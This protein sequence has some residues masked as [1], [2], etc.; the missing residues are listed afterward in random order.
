MTERT[1]KETVTF[2]HPFR[3]AAVDDLQPAGSYLVETQEELIQGLSFPAY[4]RLSTLL[5]LAGRPADG[6]ELTRLVD[7][8]PDELAALRSADAAM[9]Y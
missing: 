3:P 6:S 8:D 9:Q 2:R 4:R 5:H 1:T 7:I